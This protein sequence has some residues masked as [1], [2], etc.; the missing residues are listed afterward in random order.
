MP[1]DDERFER[2]REGLECCD[3]RP[4][5][6]V[7]HHDERL[8]TAHSVLASIEADLREARKLLTHANPAVRGWVQ[9]R[10]RLLQHSP[11]PPK[12]THD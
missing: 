2:V 4:M 12:E 6:T 1:S 7:L 10:D 11:T 8:R 9:A 5:E 3:A